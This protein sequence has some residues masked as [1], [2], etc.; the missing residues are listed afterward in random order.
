MKHFFLLVAVLVPCATSQG[1]IEWAVN[2]DRLVAVGFGIG[3][4]QPAST[5]VPPGYYGDTGVVAGT[6]GWT[7][8]PKLHRKGGASTTGN[9]LNLRG[10]VQTIFVGP[11]VTAFPT[12]T[13]TYQFEG[14]IA[15][16]EPFLPSLGMDFAHATTGLDIIR[17][18]QAPLSLPSNG[19]WFL[20]LT[21]A[22]PVALPDTELVL[23][24]QYRGGE[25]LN[26]PLG[27]Q[28]QA[29]D[30]EGGYGM[31]GATMY[32]FTTGPASG[33]QVSLASGP[34]FR[35]VQSLLVQEPVFTATGFHANRYD[36]VSFTPQIPT[37][38]ESY[39]GLPSAYADWGP[40][41]LT[42]N[43]VPSLFFD[44]RAGSNYATTGAGTV[45]ANL[46]N[47]MF[48]HQTVT[49]FGNILLNPLDPLMFAFSGF[50]FPMD[51]FGNYDQGPSSPFVLPRL[52]P[53]AVGQIVQF[54]GVIANI[55]M[56][57]TDIQFLNASGMR[58]IQ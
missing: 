49:P 23:F 2:N 3:G 18:A 36:A 10:F 57:V 55:G 52:D 38:G 4:I 41:P 30:W 43:A 13:E 14:G 25:R 48:D 27:G 5:A 39:R 37:V 35:G 19:I 56:G 32:G 17:V 53:S 50:L 24:V 26:D 22:N 44:F 20:N 51:S 33:R 1:P 21:F 28:I 58:L 16:S 11:S 31:P 40:S 54:Q 47:S 15:P 6:R 45:L 7:F 34:R 42:S 8:T 9:Y 12:M 29:A 46:G